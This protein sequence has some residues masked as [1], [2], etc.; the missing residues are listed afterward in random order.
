VTLYWPQARALFTGD[1]I[2]NGGLGRTDLPGGDGRALKAS[3][4][5]M[6]DLDADWLLSGHGDVIRGAEAVQTNFAGVERTWFDYV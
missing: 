3:I 5:R 4:R 2:F 6:A 1:L